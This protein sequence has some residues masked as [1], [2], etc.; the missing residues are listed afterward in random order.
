MGGRP[1]RQVLEH[2]AGKAVYEEDSIRI[3]DEHGEFQISLAPNENLTVH[4]WKTECA[5]FQDELDRWKDFRK[6]QETMLE[7][8][9]LKITLNSNSVDPR[10]MDIIVRLNDWRDFQYYQRRKIGL[11]LMLIHNSTHMMKEIMHE[12]SASQ[13]LTLPVEV[14]LALVN[15]FWDRQ[16]FSR[17][18]DLEAS[19]MQLTWIE[20]QILEILAEACTSLATSV[21]LLQDLE[22]KLEQQAS[23]FDQELKN[24]GAKPACPVQYPH[25]SAGLAQK[26]CHWGSEITR[27]IYEYWDWKIFLRWRKSP[28]CTEKVANAG[29]Q[30]LGGQVPDLQ[31]WR[32]YVSY[33]RYQLDRARISVA[34]W[35][36]VITFSENKTNTT[37]KEHLYML[38]STISDLR[39]KMVKF[40]Q[41]IQIA[42]LRLRSAE[43]Q[44]VELAS[45]QSCLETSYSM[46]QICTHPSLSLGTLDT[47]STAVIPEESTLPKDRRTT[48]STVSP[49]T[50]TPDSARLSK[51]L[52]T[53]E[54]IRANGHHTT[55]IQPFT[56]AE[57]M[58]P[59]PVVADDQVQITHAPTHQAP[60]SG[61]TRS[62]KR[63]DKPF[64]GRVLKHTSKEPIR[65]TKALRRNKTKAILSASSLQNSPT[66][67]PPLRRSQRL[68]EKATAP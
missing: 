66:D 8:P 1:T 42:E 34:G 12:G 58:L 62:A 60:V 30:A 55:K 56:V 48:S 22:M 31:I 4:H 39:T 23:N 38:E 21:F 51:S 43:Q 11:D 54:E 50:G 36:E 20:S 28:Q 46:Q 24:L 25:Q 19:Q 40:Q 59:G 16:I 32:D 10:L 17:Q 64:S 15:C 63:L 47:E 49:I 5:L 27:L 53:R 37:P 26:L 29:E 18:M 2:P 65:N 68:K 9:L 41:D 13:E 6:F 33:R 67:S 52:H 35:Q 3:F 45:Q 14:Q 7:V 44:L 61:K 57:A